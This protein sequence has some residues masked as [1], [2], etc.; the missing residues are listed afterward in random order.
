MSTK[1]NAVM[2]FK[3]DEYQAITNQFKQIQ[4]CI[5]YIDWKQSFYDNMKSVE[6]GRVWTLA[7]TLQTMN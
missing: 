4:E 7:K 2:A 1:R 3:D 5:D 6:G